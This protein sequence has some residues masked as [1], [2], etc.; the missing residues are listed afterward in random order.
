MK[1]SSCM[2]RSVTELRVVSV[3]IPRRFVS[4]STG[5]TQGRPPSQ[6]EDTSQGYD[7][8][9]TDS[10][11]LSRVTLVFRTDLGAPSETPLR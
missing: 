8:T 7:R 6:C 11:L 4:L 9:T 10:V 1:T 3:E 5:P 2:R